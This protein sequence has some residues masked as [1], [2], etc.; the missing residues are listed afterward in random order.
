MKKIKTP[1]I[2]D[3]DDLNEHGVKDIIPENEEYYTLDLKRG[4]DNDLDDIPEIDISDKDPAGDD[5][6]E[7]LKSSS[8][9]EGQLVQKNNN[10][11]HSSNDGGTVQQSDV[12][13]Q[14]GGNGIAGKPLGNVDDDTG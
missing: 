1:E 11:P 5:R 3:R 9:Y 13:E 12:F 2:N 4:D 7:P 8:F 6:D 10:K 14:D